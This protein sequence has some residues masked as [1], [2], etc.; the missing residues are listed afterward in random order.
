MI[1]KVQK[2]KTPAALAALERAAKKAVERARQTG[3]AAY[4]M[5]QGRIVNIAARS[6]GKREKGR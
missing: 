4:V 1:R 6:Q 2:K 3:T 5:E